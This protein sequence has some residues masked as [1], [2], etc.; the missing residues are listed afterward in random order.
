MNCRV[1]NIERHG[2]V[3]CRVADVERHGSVDCKVA[4]IER[5]GRLTAESQTSRDMAVCHQALHS[6][7]E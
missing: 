7:H 2:R 6:K 3:D 5:H 4:D 1:A